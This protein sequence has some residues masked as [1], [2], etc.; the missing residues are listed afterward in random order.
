MV[1][2][3]VSLVV[4][5]DFIYLAA[6]AYMMDLEVFQDAGWAFRRGQDLYSAEFPTRS[7]FRFIYPPFAALLFYPLTWAGP[8]TLQI[9]WTVATVAA[10]WAMLWMVFTRL[11]SE[12]PKLLAT[13]LLGVVLLLDPLRANVLFG[14][15]N[16][17][18]ALLVVSDVLGFLPK[19]LRGLG[20]GVAAGI[21]ITPAAY[22]L[23]FLMRRD[24]VAVAKSFGWFLVT[25]AL[26]FA[27]R[28]QESIYF[29]T[30]EFFAG[31][32][33]GAP[34]YEANQAF[35][36]LLA[37]AGLEGTALDIGIYGFFLFGA[38]AAAFVAWIYHRNGYDVA[39]LGFVAL[40]VSFAGPYA[41]SHHWSIVMVFVPLVLYVRE[42]WHL[43]AGALFM[44]A[45]WWAPYKVFVGNDFGRAANVGQWFYGNMQG[46]M[47]G[48]LFFTCLGY[49]IYLWR[50]PSRVRATVNA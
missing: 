3:L 24:F 31:N 40:A 22:A 8:V 6:T 29:W 21:K 20:V 34:T 15:I 19:K 48:V 45:N 36:G 32:R 28:F 27:V 4:V 47:G 46:V 14:Q 13:C 16:V 38:I 39:A 2:G 11:A 7:G 42:T 44:I 9:I 41:V 18:L 12:R 33:G 43:I 10:V 26:G 30:D 17:F 1:F 50:N 23:V 37:R 5:I 49:A 35:S 25:V